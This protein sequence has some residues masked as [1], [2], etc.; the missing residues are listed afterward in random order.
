MHAYEM[1]Y[2]RG[3]PEFLMQ[4]H[5]SAYAHIDTKNPHKIVAT[6]YYLEFYVAPTTKNRD[7]SNVDDE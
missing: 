6:D 7:V 2:S 4:T 1:C 3:N 5:Q